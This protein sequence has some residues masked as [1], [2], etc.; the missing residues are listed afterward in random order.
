MRVQ[1]LG[2][3]CFG[4]P[5]ARGST[6]RLTCPTRM[7]MKIL[8]AEIKAKH[9]L[10]DETLDS[11]ARMARELDGLILL[12]EQRSKEQEK[13]RAAKARRKGVAKG[14]LGK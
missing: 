5:A 13:Y 11:L 3:Q 12:R 14:R 6:H 10:M 8:D 7:A 9:K 2:K 1:F 4:I